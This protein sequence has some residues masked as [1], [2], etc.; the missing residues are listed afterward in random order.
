MSAANKHRGQAFA[1]C[2]RDIF[3]NYVE[4]LIKQLSFI[5]QQ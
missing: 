2:A 5:K 4:I 3:I 1:T